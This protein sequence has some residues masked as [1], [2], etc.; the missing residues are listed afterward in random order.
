MIV[1]CPWIV[2]L[3]FLAW[4]WRLRDRFRNTI[5]GNETTPGTQSGTKFVP[6]TVSLK[7]QGHKL[8]PWALSQ[9][10][11]CLDS[12]QSS[13]PCLKIVIATLLKY[14]LWE[15]TETDQTSTCNSGPRN[16]VCSFLGYTAKTRPN[17]GAIFSI[18]TSKYAKKHHIEIMKINYLEKSPKTPEIAENGCFDG[19]RGPNYNPFFNFFANHFKIYR[20]TPY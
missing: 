2:S 5:Q 20:E 7:F 17:F 1:S 4:L 18:I 11:D 8:C 6:E 15:S 16:D 10:H 14:Y 12:E 9:G 13:N 3:V 19:P